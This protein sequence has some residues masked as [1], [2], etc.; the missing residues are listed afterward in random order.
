[1]RT[2]RVPERPLPAPQRGSAK[3]GEGGGGRPA[4]TQHAAHG[5]LL[6]R[7]GR[8]AAGRTRRGDLGTAQGGAAS[9]ES[10]TSEAAESRSASIK[11]L[12]RASSPP[13]RA[14]A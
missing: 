3:P 6:L 12:I 1:G 13:S 5:A 2:L 14:S 11:A 8:P 9:P 10:G 4:G 7:P